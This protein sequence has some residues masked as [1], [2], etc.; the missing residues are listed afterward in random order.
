MLALYGAEPHS[1]STNTHKFSLYMAVGTVI[2]TSCFPLYWYINASVS[3]GDVSF[4]FFMGLG[5]LG[6]GFGL[7]LCL[8]LVWLFF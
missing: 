7:V 4:W 1:P 6:F 5:G 8:V 2:V 3:T